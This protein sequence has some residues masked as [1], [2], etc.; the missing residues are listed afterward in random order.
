MKKTYQH[1]ASVVLAVAL[2]TGV[3]SNDARATGIP[4]VD[5]SAIITALQSQ[6]NDI[7]QY[8]KELQGM[9]TDA[10]HYQEVMSHYRQQLIKLQRMV[11]TLSF[12]GTQPLNKRDDDFMVDVVC[13][14]SHGGLD[15]RRLLSV[16]QLDPNGDIVGQQR[17]ICQLRQVARNQK[18]NETIDF[19]T[20]VKAETQAELN[21][22][23]S[24]QDAGGETQ[25]GV[26]TSVNDATATSVRLSAIYQNYSTK[27][28]MYDNQIAALDDMQ[29]TLTA[30]ALKGGN[31]PIGTMVHTATLEAA[32]KIH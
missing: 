29:R 31:D 4:V 5:I 6:F 26:Q 7:A 1:I 9:A 2:G 23:A 13:D 21:E 25:G 15:L 17:T 8:A 14:G 11:S 32:L 16:F 22:M 10:A 27:V 30:A 24:R 18:F 20:R 3:A 19:L 12:S 28:Q